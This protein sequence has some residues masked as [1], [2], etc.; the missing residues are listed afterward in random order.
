MSVNEEFQSTN[1][2]LL[3]SKEELQS[4]NEELTAL[5]GQL[6]ETLERQRSTSNDLENILYSSDVATLFLDRDLNIRFFTPAVKSLFNII[7]TD[8]GRPLAD[9]TSLAGDTDLLAEARR[10]E[11]TLVPLRHEIQ[12][13]SGAWYNRR[14]FPYRT[15]DNRIEGV[16]ITFADISEIKAAERRIEAARAYA[17]SVINAIRHPLLVLDG[18]QR[19][20][21][22]NDAFYRSL[23]LTPEQAVG[24]PFAVA[25]E[26]SRENNR[27]PRPPRPDR[28]RVCFQ[29]GVRDRSRAAW[30]RPPAL[31]L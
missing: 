12:T 15:H 31:A 17:E 10:V 1:E 16:V 27:A 13:N 11:T 28:S 5:N 22:A 2:E 8:I 18:E 29:C 7:A 24:R 6:H 25:S 20:V 30:A 4:L 19:I 26:S 14:I 23:A 3:T 9:L 21:S